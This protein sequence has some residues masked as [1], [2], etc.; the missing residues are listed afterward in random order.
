MATYKVIQDIEAEDKILGPLTLRQFI[1]A[2]ITCFFLYLCFIAVTK[3][4]A[5]L[6]VLFVPPALFTG[7]FA[8][9]FGRDQPTE[10]WAVAKLGFLF[11]PRK[12]IWDQSGIKELVTVT[13][14]K[15]IERVYTNGLS[16]TEVASRLSALANTIDSRGWA[17]KNVNVNL[18]AQ[19]VMG[20][21]DDSDR[22]VAMSSLPQAVVDYDVKASDD[23]LDVQ[24]NPI[25][26]QFTQM[27][28]ASAQ[29]HRQQLI[30]SMNAPAVAAL[31]KTEPTGSDMWFS[32][33]G[34]TGQPL[35]ADMPFTPPVAALSA[36]PTA[37]ELA[38]LDHLK[39]ENNSHPD[40]NAH[41][42]TIQPLSAQPP[43]GPAAAPATVAVI[44][45]PVPAQPSPTIQ[46]LA[47]SNDLNIATLQREAKRA[48]T[49][50]DL[51]QDEVVIS[52]R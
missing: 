24:S 2:L 52:L 7:F 29:A 44:E 46:N 32:A 47:R 48:Q 36:T 3:H 5:F 30:D 21:A 25:A 49:T 41:M 26:Q 28:S 23:I 39:A 10:V 19:P 11:K 15:R 50:N 34:A 43:A 22:L 40:Y 14:P 9:P 51:G 42:K 1:Y 45:A 31:A 16:Q 38:F 8:A 35:P 17:V 20:M 12:R 6:L 13:V 33:T 27:I 18:F 4:A 37:D